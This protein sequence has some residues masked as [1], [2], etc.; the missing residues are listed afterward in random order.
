MMELM[1]GVIKTYESQSGRGTMAGQAAELMT[2][3]VIERMRVVRAAVK[4][5]FS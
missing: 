5:L 4:K 1:D 3:A 2:P